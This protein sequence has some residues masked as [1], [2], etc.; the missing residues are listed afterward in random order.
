MIR[1]PPRSTRTD[2]LIPYTTL[3]RSIRIGFSFGGGG[4][5]QRF[6]R[7]NSCTNEHYDGVARSNVIM[8]CPNDVGIYLNK[9]KGTLIHNNALIN[10][11]GIDVRFA[12]TSAL[13]VNNV[14]DGRI[15]ARSGGQYSQSNNIVDPLAAAFLDQVSQ[16]I[17]ADPGKGDLRLNELDRVLGKGLR[18]EDPGLDICGQPYDPT[19]PDIGPIQYGMELSCVPVFP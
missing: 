17:Y 1:R 9:S 2:T 18:I 14:I 19:A 6:C 12:G 10:T 15:L 7:N 8:D 16:E 4:T 3:F 11:R 13:I 5:A